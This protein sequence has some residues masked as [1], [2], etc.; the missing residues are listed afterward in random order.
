MFLF[1]LYTDSNMTF[2]LTGECLHIDAVTTVFLDVDTLPPFFCMI[3]YFLY[4]H[5]HNVCAR[6][7]LH[8]DTIATFVHVDRVFFGTMETLTLSTFCPTWNTW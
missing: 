2:V 6:V 1:F 4:E 3:D 5:C 8:I 7:V